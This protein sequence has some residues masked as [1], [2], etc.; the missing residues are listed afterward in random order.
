MRDLRSRLAGGA[1]WLAL[2][3]GVAPGCS[4]Q[5]AGDVSGPADALPAVPADLLAA[6]WPVV[7]AADADRAR[8]E[9]EPGWGA[10]V[11]DRNYRSGVAQLGG[12]GGLLAARAHADAASVYRQAALAAAFAYVE[13]Y[14]KTPQDTDPAGTAH[15]LTVSYAVIGDRAAAATHAAALPADDASA[16]WNT[17][18]KAWLGAD[19]A[20]ATWPPDLSTL[21]IALPAVAPGEWPEIEGM[22]HYRLP[23]RAPGTGT[24]EYGDPGL[25]V[26]IALWHDAAARQAAGAESAAVETYMARYRLPA[27]GPVSATAELPIELL[28]GA[29]YL[30][31]GDGPFLAELTGAKGAAAVDDWASRSL[32]A[33]LAQQ[34][35]VNGK[36]E[37]ERAIDLVANLRKGLLEAC[38]QKNG[39][40]EIG[41]HRTFADVAVAGALRGLALVAEAEG[42]REQSGIL[43][44]NA[45]EKSVDAA[46][47]PEGLLSLAAWDASNR[48]PARGNDII[49]T[50][51]RR[52]PSLETARY[53]LDVLALRVSRE[54][55]DQLPGM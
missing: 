27:E 2:V 4:G 23:E 12:K 55:T 14:G 9:A 26:A 15:L 33:A 47:A 48:Y 53:G 45:M 46:A 19:P 20:A 52:Y 43:R 6:A 16:A 3:A 29:D 42:D 7:V 21:P 31:P 1:L 44:I 11:A 38:K 28:F 8:F 50:L 17:P 10:L 54:R 37:A 18:W 25:L 41:V 51:V 24:V 22:P 39:G 35:R 13:T 5:A 32:I 40:A 36:V 49:H 34:S 30:V